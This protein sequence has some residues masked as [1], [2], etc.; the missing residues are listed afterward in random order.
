MRVG[1]AAFEVSYYSHNAASQY[2][3]LV[4]RVANDLAGH[5]RVYSLLIPTSYGVTMPDDVKPQIAN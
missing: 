3:N 2:A 5:T 4:S 1:N